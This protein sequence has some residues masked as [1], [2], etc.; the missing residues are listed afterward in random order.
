MEKGDRWY[1]ARDRS[2]VTGKGG[3]KH[4]RD[5]C[6]VLAHLSLLDTASA[7]LIKN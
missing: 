4:E 2:S 1:L 3:Q 5:I 6:H 7:E